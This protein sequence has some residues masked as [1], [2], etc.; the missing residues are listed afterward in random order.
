MGVVLCITEP[1]ANMDLRM[2][3]PVKTG[4]YVVSYPSTAAT[5]ALAFQSLGYAAETGTTQTTH[6][7]GLVHLDNAVNQ[8]TF[9]SFLCLGRQARRAL[10]SARRLSQ[11]PKQQPP[12]LPFAN[13]LL[14]RL[15]WILPRASSETRATLWSLTELREH[16]HIRE[17]QIHPQP[18][19]TPNT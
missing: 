2:D 15:L 19:P 6:G 5:L 7:H 4:N 9:I 14:Q 3:P 18:S 12:L 11:T 16:P 17:E 10:R 8:P 13:I 1:A